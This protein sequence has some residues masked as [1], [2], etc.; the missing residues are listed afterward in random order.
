[1]SEYECFWESEV[2][3]EK[4]AEGPGGVYELSVGCE[5]GGTT[6]QHCTPPEEKKTNK[7]HKQSKLSPYISDVRSVT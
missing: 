6:C 7:K 1:M 3:A 5:T 2:K 4:P